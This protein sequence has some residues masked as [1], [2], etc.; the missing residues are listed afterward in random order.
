MR[1]YQLKKDIKSDKREFVVNNLLELKN[2]IKDK[3]PK[4]S[5]DK[6]LLI[7]TWNI[8]DFDSNK[9]NHG[10]RLKESYFYI[11]QMVSEFDLIAVQ[12]VNKN[13]KALYKLMYL[14]GDK[15]NYITT[16]VTAGASGNQERMTFIYD[17][18][19]VSFK[20]VAGE[21]VLPQTSLIQGDIQFA[22]TPFMVS[23]QSGWTKFSLCTVHIYFG[24]DSG[25]KLVRRQEEIA[26]IAKFLKKKADSD[27]ETL[28]VLGD[29][30][31]VDHE[32]KTMEALLDNGFKIPEQIRKKP[33][34]TNTFQTK[35]YDQIGIRSKSGFFQLGEEDNSAGTFNFFNHVFRENQ[36]ED[37]KPEV[38]KTLAKQLKRKEKELVKLQG[39]ETPNTE[40]IDKLTNAIAD[41]KAMILNDNELFEYY[42]K[43]WKT[44]QISDHLPM[45]VEIKVDHSEDY[46]KGIY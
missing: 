33:E 15:W 43:T 11:A 14:L 31:I 34:G 29:F 36:F 19:R 39:K 20:N 38:I 8:R 12:E 25:V 21:V 3:V 1:Y 22:R 42:Y 26:G 13:L 44:F 10:P 27:K 18:R 17:T 2:A 41:L 37:Y 6:N 35:Y 23:F 5:L 24:A 40:D 16:D 45:W 9:F 7:A 46:L 28:M 30:N 4:K 32:H